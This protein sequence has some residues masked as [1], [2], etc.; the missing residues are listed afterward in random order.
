MV[1]LK[2]GGRKWQ[3]DRI[4]GIFACFTTLNVGHRLHIVI[5][6]TCH[7][8][9]FWFTHPPGLSFSSHHEP[10]VKWSSPVWLCASAFAWLL[11]FQLF[12]LY[13]Q[14]YC[15]QWKEIYNMWKV[16]LFQSK[17]RNWNEFMSHE[18]SLFLSV[19]FDFNSLERFYSCNHRA[20]TIWVSCE[21]CS[22]I[23]ITAN[24]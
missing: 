15:V 22:W 21:M 6:M 4:V 5:L 3:W 19:K 20:M 23:H 1:I 18:P 9:S 2:G 8:Y 12:N 11:H 13:S 24:I 17:L 16:K 14:G 10:Q 7:A